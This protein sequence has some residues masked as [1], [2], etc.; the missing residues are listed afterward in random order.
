MNTYY[1][2]RKL[3][4]EYGWPDR[5][6]GEAFERARGEWNERLEELEAGGESPVVDYEGGARVRELAEG[7]G[8]WLKER[9]G[10]EAV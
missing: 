4:R 5:F 7:L 2:M 3:Y 6:S 9:A 1:G 10:E 8:E